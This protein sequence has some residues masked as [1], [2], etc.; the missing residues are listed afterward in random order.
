LGIEFLRGRTSAS[1]MC[2]LEVVCDRKMEVFRYKL[3]E[4][5]YTTVKDFRLVKDIVERN[6]KGYRKKVK[7][8]FQGT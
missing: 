4:L 8:R 1:Q 6:V 2:A 3:V 5:G 7:M